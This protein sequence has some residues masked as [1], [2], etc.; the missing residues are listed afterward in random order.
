M[1]PLVTDQAQQNT[2]LQHLLQCAHHRAVL[3]VG[4]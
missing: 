3:L 4:R 1:E 2:T